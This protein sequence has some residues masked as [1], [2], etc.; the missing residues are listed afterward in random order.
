[1][2]RLLFLSGWCTLL[3]L[4]SFSQ[5]ISVPAGM[6]WS[7][8]LHLEGYSARFAG[9]SQP[10]IGEPSVTGGLYFDAEART[11]AR[12]S[13]LLGAGQQRTDGW[14]TWGEVPLD[15]VF[16]G[17]PAPNF[18]DR[19]LADNLTQHWRRTFIGGGAQVNFR[20]GSGDL[21]LGTL[22]TLDRTTLLQTIAF[23]RSLVGSL[24]D[25]NDCSGVAPSRMLDGTATVNYRPVYRPGGRLR[26]LYTHWLSA[27]LAV[28]LGGTLDV[29]GGRV[30]GAYRE[31]FGDRFA[32]GE[33]SH[34]R[35]L[36]RGV[37]DYG[38]PTEG[39]FV[40]PSPTETYL[41]PGL[42]AGLVF[43]PDGD[44]QPLPDATGRLGWG[45]VLRT[46]TVNSDQ[47]AVGT[48]FSRLGGITGMY[49]TRTKWIGEIH[50]NLYRQTVS[51]FRAAYAASGVAE[52]PDGQYP[53][54]INLRTSL[55]GW[56]A[57]G[58][59]VALLP[60]PWQ[61]DGGF[62]F[63]FGG[64]VLFITRQDSRSEWFAQNE[65]G[66]IYK[67][68]RE[69][70]HLNETHQVVRASQEKSQALLNDAAMVLDLGVGYRLSEGLQVSILRTQYL[71]VGERRFSRNH[72]RY[73]GSLNG[74]ELQLAAQLFTGRD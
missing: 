10:F 66:T 56:S 18:V 68:G 53:S 72:L 29:V 58:L 47:E 39:Y 13:W 42:T 5:K 28:R 55:S 44:A 54:S 33:V 21:S 19:R 49:D 69:G 60:S 30:A 16:A 7:F 25:G 67:S 74:I 6:Q 24:C 20:I 52:G 27:N 14:A 63:T 61:N 43:K 2:L 41:L 35:T 50:L 59:T 26:L 65:N 57:T 64:G 45:V 8:A 73:L 62:L 22:L 46:G 34:S 32:V 36:A 31:G 40:T 38:L 70:Y 23:G 3:P 4:C 51:G 15:N 11:S 12:F 1:M 9:E 48:G 71:G 17:R 37:D